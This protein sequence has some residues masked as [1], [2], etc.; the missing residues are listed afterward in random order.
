MN[1]REINFMAD[2][3]NKMDRKASVAGDIINDYLSHHK[4]IDKADF[5]NVVWGVIRAYARLKWAYP[6]DNWQT[7]VQKF[8]EKGVPDVS[9]APQYIQ[10][11][12][13]EWFLSHV[14]EPEQ[15]LPTLMDSAPIVLR[16][17]G[18]RDEILNDLQQAFRS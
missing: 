7:R 16:A 1:E 10:W 13:P 18:N 2:L 4:N 12:V 5:L 11:E 15:E 14:P 3:M 6:D 17:I 8:V 9:N